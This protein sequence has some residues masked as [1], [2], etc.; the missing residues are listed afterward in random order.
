MSRIAALRR[1][2]ELFKR[3]PADNDLR[4]QSMEAVDFLGI[5]ES[6]SLT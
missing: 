1:A 6:L 2:D 5:Q 3:I 4:G